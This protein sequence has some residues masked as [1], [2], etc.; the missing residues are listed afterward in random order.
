MNANMSCR[1][2]TMPQP[3]P[4]MRVF[5]LDDSDFDRAR[6]KRLCSQSGLNVQFFESAD[7]DSMQADEAFDGCDVFIVDFYLTDKTGAQ[8]VQLLRANERVAEAGIIMVSGIEPEDLMDRSTQSGCDLYLSKD[9]LSPDLLRNVLVDLYVVR[10][11]RLP[12]QKP[13]KTISFFDDPKRLEPLDSD[14]AHRRV[15][16][17]WQTAQG[18]VLFNSVRGSRDKNNLS[19]HWLSDEFVF[20]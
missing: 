19:K 15:Q 3:L 9:R 10:A 12:G 11:A 18:V 7:F 14:R 6:I 17:S 20:H 5:V 8:V 1:T 4:P 13:S 2:G 16:R